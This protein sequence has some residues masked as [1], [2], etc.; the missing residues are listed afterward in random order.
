MRNLILGLL[1]AALT[2][3]TS[4]RVFGSDVQESQ[5]VLKDLSVAQLE[6]KGDNA[7]F[8][9]DF[10]EAVRYFEAAIRRDSRN[11]V[12]HNKLG[13]THL[14]QND[15]KAARFNFQKAG[16]LNSKYADAMNNLGAVYYM[17]KDFGAAARQFKKAVA[18]DETRSTFHVNLGAAWFGQKKLDRAIAEYARALELN[19]D[20]L[21]TGNA[22]VAAQIAS[23]E[24]RARYSYMLA[25]IFAKRGDADLCLK[26]LRKAKEEGYREL[27]DVYKDAE[28]AQ[29]RTD[30][31]LTEIAPPPAK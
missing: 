27:A 2:L 10:D 3:G 9:K 22:G 31:R 7:R 25:K 14:R 17:Q 4:A 11:A 23:P 29:L 5:P 16:K 28:F 18:L 1:V 6:A 30:P 20:A 19:P 21:S 8:N 12:L 15:L 26:H 13:L 24:E